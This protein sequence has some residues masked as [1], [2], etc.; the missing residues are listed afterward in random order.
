MMPAKPIR[1]LLLVL[2]CN[3]P[4]V[5]EPVSVPVAADQAADF[6]SWL[7]EQPDNPTAA[8][9]PSLQDTTELLAWLAWWQ[10]DDVTEEVN[11]VPE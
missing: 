10:S 9:T 11:H 7:A 4:V 1:G 8:A 2:A 5:A 3:Q 6:F